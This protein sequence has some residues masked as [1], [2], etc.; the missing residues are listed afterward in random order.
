MQRMDGFTTGFNVL[1]SA[2]RALR[3]GSRLPLSGRAK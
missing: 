2:E 1:A 3:F